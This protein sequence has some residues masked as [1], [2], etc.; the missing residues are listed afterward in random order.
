M[1]IKGHSLIN[2]LEDFAIV[3]IKNLK[4]PYISL[5][6]KSHGEHNLFLHI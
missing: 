3:N 2:L 4:K 5:M 6:L 1:V